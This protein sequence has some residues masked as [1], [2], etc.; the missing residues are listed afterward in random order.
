MGQGLLAP[1]FQ[2]IDGALWCEGV[3]LQQLAESAGTP[4]YVYSSSSIRGQFARLSGALAAIPHRVH[5]AVKANGNLAILALLRSLGCDVDVVS[6]GELHRAFAA[7]FQADRTIFGGVGKTSAELAYALRNGVH[8]LSVESADELDIIDR[9]AG[10]L[11]VRARVGLRVNPEVTVESTH[12][13]IKTGQKGDKFGI[14]VDQALTVATRAATLPN[15]AL[16]A[17]GMH[18]GSQLTDLAAYGDGLVRLEELI[19]AV[20][21]LG[22]SSLEYLDV[23]GGLFVPYADEDPA[24]LERY[25]ALIRPV[26]E[27][28]RLEQMRQRAMALRLMRGRRG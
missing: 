18:I 17:I 5:Y 9:L 16:V 28:T 15:V 12:D 27:R 20:R 21:S 24:D 11:G 3:P 10:D 13:Y 4:A 14:P 8:V 19:V 26:V 25:V 1:S 2:R 22:V 23:G 7:G 6:G